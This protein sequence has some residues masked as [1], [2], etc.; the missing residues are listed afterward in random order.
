VGVDGS[1]TSLRA[2]EWAAREACLRGA[3]LEVVHATFLRREAMELEVVAPL[4]AR[5]SAILDKA[6]AKAGTMAPGLVVVARVVDPPAAN[7]LVNVSKNADL[8][9]VGSRGLGLLKEFA[10]GSV[11]QDCSR[12]AQC[13]LVIIGPRTLNGA[14]V[15]DEVEWRP[16]VGGRQP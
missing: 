8:L 12:Q 16:P 15:A 5:E 13:P 9:V 2:L 10:L 6:V 14:M 1:P 7:A 4:K 3:I 11:S